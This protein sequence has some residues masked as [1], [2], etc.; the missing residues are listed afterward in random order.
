MC[1][2]V[3]KWIYII[4]FHNADFFLLITNSS[5]NSSKLIW[6]STEVSILQQQTQVIFLEFLLEFVTIGDIQLM[7][8][9][10]C[11]IVKA[12]LIYQK[13]F[14]LICI[15]LYLSYSSI[16]QSSWWLIIIDV[17]QNFEEV[18]NFSNKH[19]RLQQNQQH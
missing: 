12:E 6:V 7:Q 15:T 11:R 16:T 18:V 5:R 14:N 2:A 13:F 10:Y 1:Y 8:N 17:A 19:K 4:S 9:C 3:R